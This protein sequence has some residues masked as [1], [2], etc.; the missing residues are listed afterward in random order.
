MFGQKKWYHSR[1]IM[2]AATSIFLKGLA[3][4]GVA[5]GNIDAEQVT[6]VLL[7]LGSV[8]AD[9]V[10]IYGRAVATKAVK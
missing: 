10:A 5:T 9:I 7:V 3:M 4:L 6:T 1:T 2:G 8:I